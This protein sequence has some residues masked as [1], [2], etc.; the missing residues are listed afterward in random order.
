MHA[1]LNTSCRFVAVAHLCETTQRITHH[2][3]ARAHAARRFGATVAAYRFRACALD[4]QAERAEKLPFGQASHALRMATAESRLVA[5]ALEII[6][7][8][9]GV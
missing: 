3:V 1:T 4:R 9:E 2:I 7:T 6:E 8:K 5:E